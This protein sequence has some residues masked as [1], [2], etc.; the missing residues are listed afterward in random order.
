M[1]IEG[2]EKGLRTPYSVR[3]GISPASY[4]GV[5]KQK[6]AHMLTDAQGVDGLN[7][8]ILGGRPCSRPGQTKVN[9][10][11]LEPIHGFHD[12]TSEEIGAS[13][14][15]AESD[16]GLVY[17]CALNGSRESVIMVYDTVAH[18]VTDHTFDAAA[19][20]FYSQVQ[21]F[22]GSDGKI[23]AGSYKISAPGGAAD[24]IGVAI[25]S[26][27]LTT[28]AKTLVWEVAT[29]VEGPSSAAERYNTAEDPL[30]ALKF[31]RGFTYKVGGP[32]TGLVYYDGSLDDTY[33]PPFTSAA[34]VA[35]PDF[36]AFNG[37]IYSAWETSG[38]VVGSI[39]KRTGAGTWANLT[40]PTPPANQFSPQGH[41]A[42]AVLGGKA[43]VAGSY[44]G[45]FD[46]N[47]CYFLSVDTADGVTIEHH[48]TGGYRPSLIFTFGSVIVYAYH[49]TFGSTWLGVYDGV[50]WTDAVWDGTIGV[51]SY[52]ALGIGKLG[53]NLYILGLQDSVTMAL[54]R[55]NGSDLTNWSVMGG[56]GGTNAPASGVVIGIPA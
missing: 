27:D 18:T 42:P 2:K 9:V 52:S 53:S 56:G 35:G 31:V 15:A 20:P 26:L 5:S 33:V 40:M 25:H 34:Q 28:F 14:V 30:A 41:T 54:I 51:H 7:V 21:L 43:F 48:I 46:A 3:F 55:S 22:R 13:A 39:R 6:P 50:T 38:V 49:D 11:A 1:G 36:F 47:S 37:A 12:S 10:D 45:G 17:F 44:S 16:S 32:Q 29:A 8:R 24:F 23:Y 4:L 19:T